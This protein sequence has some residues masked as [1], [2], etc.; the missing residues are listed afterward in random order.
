MMMCS[1]QKVEDV[2]MSTDK[3]QSF[4]IKQKNLDEMILEIIK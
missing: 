3:L 1:L 4:G 2:S